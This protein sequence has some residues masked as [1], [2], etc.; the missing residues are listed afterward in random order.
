[1]TKPKYLSALEISRPIIPGFFPDPSV[2]RVESEYVLVN[3]SFEYAPGVPVHTSTDLVNWQQVGYALPTRS[4]LNVD[5]QGNSMG[6]FAPTI[7]HH[8]GKFYMITTSMDGKWQVLVTAEA[9]A[10]PWSDPVRIDVFGIDPDLAWDD[11]GN[12]IMTYASLP[13]NGIGQAIIST[14]TGELLTEP[15]L[16]WQGTGGK[17]PEGPHLYKRDGYWYIL[18]AEGGTERGHAVAVGRS[19]NFDGPFEAAPNSPLLSNRGTDITIQNTGHA[20]FV[21]KT[22]GSWAMVFHGTR[23]RGASP[24]WH[25]LGRET[26]AVEIDWVEGWPTLGRPIEPADELPNPESLVEKSD[27]PL[28]W[29]APASWPNELLKSTDAGLE[30]SGFV[31]RRQLAHNFSLIADLVPAESGKGEVGVE[32]R[33]DNRHWLRLSYKGKTV[34]AHW[35]IGDHVFTIGSVSV[36]LPFSFSLESV[37]RDGGF[38]APVGPDEL[39]A[40]VILSTG[41]KVELGRIDGRYVSTEVAGGMTGRVIGI[42]AEGTKALLK[43]WQ[44][45]WH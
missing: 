45:N 5:G 34:E 12:C 13:L 9:A 27:L 23:P 38:H 3:S 4:Q 1:M 15:K 39:V 17:F 18:I 43:T 26:C 19:V 41:E 14:E 33:I 8:D 21:E 42:H 10:G 6:I 40:A 28:D 7:R 30:F 37:T 44:L 36:K 20:D 24:E 22:D 2:V 25:I 16:V 29:I 11:Q 31:A 35:A 32:V